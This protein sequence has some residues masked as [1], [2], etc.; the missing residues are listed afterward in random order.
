MDEMSEHSIYQDEIYDM[1]KIS[2][3]YH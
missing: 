2:T 3:L 1:V